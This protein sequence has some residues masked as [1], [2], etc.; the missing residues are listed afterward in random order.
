MDANPTPETP[1]LLRRSDVAR[2]LSLSIRSVDKLARSG[3]LPTVRIGRSVRFIEADLRSW[4]ARNR[5][6]NQG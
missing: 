3:Q 5:Q 6:D 2:L 1:I 4:A